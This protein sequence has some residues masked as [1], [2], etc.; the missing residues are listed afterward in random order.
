MA[1]YHIGTSGWHYADWRGLF[2]PE[3]LPKWDWLSF[4]ARQFSTVE[5]NASFYRLPTEGAFKSWYKATPPDFL[6]TLKVSRF[7]THIKHLLDAGEAMA[8]F[9]SRARLLKEKLGPLLYQL[10]PGMSRNDERLES[11]L[12]ILP[13]ELKHVFEFRNESWLD[14]SVFTILRK[15]NAGFCV[16]DMPGFTSPLIATTDFAY[17]RFHGSQSLYSSSYS[18]E[19]LADWAKRI[20]HLARNLN[21]VY[22][23][24]NNDVAGYAIDNARTIRRY[25]EKESS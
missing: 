15:H 3:D 13:R 7:I 24:F 9:L 11:F 2:Y 14:E 17:I 5:L 19:E 21:S 16:A 20:A 12:T 8:A 25:L 1:V 4:Y 6:F 23:Y 18:D 22:I 10:P